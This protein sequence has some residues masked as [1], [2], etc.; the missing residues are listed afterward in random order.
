[1]GA[2]LK[3]YA[4]PQ[5]N[6]APV[7][8]KNKGQGAGILGTA[9]P[10]GCYKCRRIGR[11]VCSWTQGWAGSCSRGRCE[12][13]RV[14][15]QKGYSLVAGAPFRDLRASPYA[16]LMQGLMHAQGSVVF[17]GPAEPCMAA[18][19]SGRVGRCAESPVTLLW[20]AQSQA[21]CESPGLLRNRL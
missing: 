15:S 17:S 1:M 21:P 4:A 18:F 11:H 9:Q 7:S 19:F 10:D 12:R 3:G 8:G 5:N 14:L 6:F 16:I 2:D 13:A 20:Q